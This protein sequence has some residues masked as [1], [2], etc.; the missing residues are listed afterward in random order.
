MKK[1]IAQEPSPTE[2]KLYKRS[3]IKTA[4]I[5]AFIDDILLILLMFLLS[6]V[7]DPFTGRSMFY[8]DEFMIL[9]IPTYAWVIFLPVTL[10]TTWIYRK[11]KFSV[12]FELTIIASFGIMMLIGISLF[13]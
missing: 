12:R 9:C 7:S 6:K 4:L 3:I 11:L 13:L 1:P 10:I 5:A 8:L 2:P